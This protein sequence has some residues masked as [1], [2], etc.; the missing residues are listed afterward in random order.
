M[1]QSTYHSSRVQRKVVSFVRRSTRMRPQHQRVLATYRDRFVLDVPRGETSTSIAPEA[2][3]DVGATFGRTGPLI[4]EV[5]P[6]TGESLVAMAA[7]R[8]EANVVA[9]EVYQPGIARTLSRLVDDHVDN[10]RIVEADAVDGFRHL[11]AP[12]SVDRVWMFFPDPWH[13]ARHHKRRIVTTEFAD[14]VASRMRRGATW[15]LATDWEDYAGQMRE[16]LGSHPGFL[17]LHPAGWAPR[18]SAR[19]VT[20]FEQ[21]GLDAGRQVFDLGYRRR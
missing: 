3:L 17:T 5:G 21:R 20:R 18:W 14:L 1:A 7:A 19:P 8:P 9:F 13:K 10:V 12:G 6:G 2:T 11:L 4:V 16:V 15:R